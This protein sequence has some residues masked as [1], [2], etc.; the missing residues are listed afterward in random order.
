MANV[1]KAH[2]NLGPAADCLTAGG[3]ALV[4]TETVYGVGVAISAFAANLETPG[5]DT[6][7]GRIFTLKQRE[8]TQT[9]PWLVDGPAA[10]ERYGK[11]VPHSICALAEKL[12][13]GALTLVVPAADDVPPF[14]RAADGTV[15]LRASASPVVQELI[16]RCGSPLAVTSANTHGKSAPISFDEVEP[17]ILAGV[18]VAVDAGETP[19]RDAS[20]IVAVRDG[21]LQILREGALAVREI[22]AVLE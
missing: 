8:L 9:V 6:G 13:P 2:D 21:E 16:A 22:R 3:L 12:W 4:P 7:Y 11:D 17:R 18:D 15:A 20:T 14:M 10:L 19:C 5:P 1:I